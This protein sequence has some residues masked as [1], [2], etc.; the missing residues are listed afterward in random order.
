VR[1]QGTWMSDVSPVRI[2]RGERTDA[3]WIAPIRGHMNFG[4]FPL[5][6]VFKAMHKP[7]LIAAAF[8]GT[9]ELGGSLDAPTA[10][11]KGAIVPAKGEGQE[12]P[13]A[14]VDIRYADGAIRVDKLNTTE[15]LDLKLTGTFPLAF[16]FHDGA[17]VESGK[18][19]DFKLEINPRDEEP[20]EVGRY[21]EGVSLLRGILTAN[22]VGGGTPA[23]P[24]L[25]GGLAFTRGQLRVTGLEEE[26]KDIA[27]RVDFIDDVVRLTTLSARSGKKG[28]LVASGWTRISDYKPSDYKLD[29]TMR[30]FEV[31]SVS[32]I[33][34]KTD[35]NL[36]VR[37]VN[38]R[39]GRRIPRITG[40]LAIK[41]ADITMD[42]TQR[43]GGAS[44]ADFTRPTA[45]P[46]WLAA[47][48]IDAAKNVWIRNPDLSV[49]LEG[50]LILNR[51][52]RGLYFRGDMSILRGNYYVYGNKFQ[53]TD[54]TFDFSASETLRPSMQI[55]AYTPYVGSRDFTGPE[56]NIYLS[57]SWPY[58]QKEP[59]IKLTFEGA[60]GYSDAEIW[61]LLAGN[62]IGAGCGDQRAPA[63]DR[64]ADDRRPRRPAGA[65]RDRS[66]LDLKTDRSRGRRAEIPVAGHLCG[67][68]ARA[69]L[70][71]RAGSQRGVPFGQEIPY[72]FQ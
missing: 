48:D 52:E 18:P 28:S 39:D 10:R 45:S 7:T 34:V 50:D 53:I 15:E 29:V 67:L 72:T 62:N 36:T 26:F 70:P 20:V 41:E 51:D 47:V 24:R 32:D 35:G 37:L 23:S 64:F 17:R 19:L 65:A 42:I 22:V 56:Q 4:H 55:N 59:R 25:S 66:H 43:E 30:E 27:L 38:W 57:L 8:D 9:I 58:D 44:G 2:A 69:V 1:A 71:E 5:A 21:I 46:N 11:L 33:K 60:P 61:A 13:P 68:P 16:S 3:L 49:E 40:R 12:L 14:E 63:R 31:E 54:G 6:T